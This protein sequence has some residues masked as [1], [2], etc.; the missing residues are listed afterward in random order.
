MLTSETNERSELTKRRRCV[1]IAHARRARRRP[2]PSRPLASLAHMLARAKRSQ[3]S[4][5]STS[6][7]AAQSRPKN[8]GADSA[9]CLFQ[10]LN[11]ASR[12][13]H[14]NKVR[15]A[16]LDGRDVALA[17]QPSPRDVRGKQP[18]ERLSAPTLRAPPLANPFLRPFRSSL[19]QVVVLA[20]LPAAAESPRPQRPAPEPP[21]T[22]EA[23]LPPSYGAASSDASPDSRNHARPPAEITARRHANWN[24]SDTDAGAA[25]RRR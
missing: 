6:V 9:T 17:A 20:L 15:R 16:L 11:A 10:G 2:P 5:A 12:C 3:H 22:D 23:S 25:S 4:T 14:T 19:C 8:R 13:D 18:L 7:T 21:A 24:A 1:R